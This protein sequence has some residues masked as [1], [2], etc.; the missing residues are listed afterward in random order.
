M[1]SAVIAKPKRN[2]FAVLDIGT[3][4]II[5]LIVKINGNFSYKV[6]GTGYKIAEGVNG[7]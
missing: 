2:V 5:C 6:T 4:K 7:G 3:T 1:Y